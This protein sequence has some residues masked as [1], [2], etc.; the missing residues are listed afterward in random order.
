MKKLFVGFMALVLGFTCAIPSG[1]AASFN[2]D[3][4]NK[5]VEMEESLVKNNLSVE[6]LLLDG[7]SYEL[8]KEI[9]ESYTEI[10]IK[11]ELGVETVKYDN[12][13]KIM[14]INDEPIP[15]EMQSQLNSISEMVKEE[16]TY[17]PYADE[18]PEG[19]GG[20]WKWV[21]TKNFPFTI[22][23]FTAIAAATALVIFLGTLDEK[24]KKVSNAVS[25]IAPS[26]AAIYTMVVGD[27]FYLTFK[28]WTK[29]HPQFPVIAVRAWWWLEFYSSSSRTVMTDKIS[30]DTDY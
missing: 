15:E 10:T 29:P 30:W 28:K 24:F 17:T 14:I 19:G 6:T 22:K 12:E 21:F 2:E 25:A 9:T 16:S 4:A 5:A 3:E 8:T 7:V 23:G 1:F 11:S 20:E 26:V 18:D 13:A 27:Y